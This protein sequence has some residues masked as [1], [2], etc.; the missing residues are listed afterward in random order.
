MPR[1]ESSLQSFL[2]LFLVKSLFSLNHS[3]HIFPEF[4]RNS[5]FSQ[6]R[7]V[8]HLVMTQMSQTVRSSSKRMLKRR[9]TQVLIMIVLGPQRPRQK[10]LESHLRVFLSQGGHHGF[11]TLNT[12]LHQRIL[13][14]R[15][16]GNRVNHD[17]TI[18]HV[19]FQRITSVR[20]GRLET[21]RGGFSKHWLPMRFEKLDQVLSGW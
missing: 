5:G 8:R 4:G 10:F 20:A 15:F 3:F 7:N 11:G 14:M 2:V 18:G 17:V 6:N 16:S 1:Q 9:K 21:N 12:P 19:L 13:P